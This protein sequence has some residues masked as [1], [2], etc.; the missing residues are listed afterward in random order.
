MAVGRS[1]IDWAPPEEVV[2]GVQEEDGLEWPA[3]C[4]RS[5]RDVGQV[6][7]VKTG[8]LDPNRLLNL[9]REG[10]ERRGDVDAYRDL[11]RG[12]RCG[13]EDVIASAGS[14]VEEAF[15]PLRVKRRDRAPATVEPIGGD[16]P[17]FRDPKAVSPG[18]ALKIR[19]SAGSCRNPMP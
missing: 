16:D 19:T 1:R 8:T 7:H 15:Q 11:A 4:R 13:L 17:I 9:P 18:I 10:D 5:L 6:R 2:I 14:N 12:V 3:E